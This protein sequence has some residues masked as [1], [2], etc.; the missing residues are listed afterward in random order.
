MMGL[1]GPAHVCGLAHGVAGRAEHHCPVA[2]HGRGGGVNGGLPSLVGHYE[3]GEA[4]HA[5]DGELD[6]AEQLTQSVNVA[7]YI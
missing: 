7:L 5:P 1:T 2:S 4:V 6:F 3:A